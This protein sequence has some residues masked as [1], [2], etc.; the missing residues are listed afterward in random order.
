MGRRSGALILIAALCLLAWIWQQAGGPSWYGL[1]ALSLFAV[2]I[3][4]SWRPHPAT[5]Q[6]RN[7]THND[8]ELSDAG[9]D[10]DLTG[11]RIG[12]VVPVYN[13]DPAMLMACLESLLAQTRPVTSVVVIDDCSTD[14]GAYREAQTLHYRFQ[15]AG[16]ALIT[17]RFDHNQGKRHAL[18]RALELQP[19]IDVLVGV[20]SDTI[21][22]PEAIGRLTQAYNRPGVTVVTGLVLA[23][24]WDRNLLTRLIDL[25]YAQAF[26]V[27]R[28][29]QSRFGSM[30]CACGSLAMYSARVLRK[31]KPDFLNQRFLGQPAIF[32]D[33]RRLTNY[34]L[35]EGKAILEETAIA[36]TAVPEHLPHFLRQQIRWNKSFFR[37][38]LW[39]LRAMPIGKPAFWFTLAEL[40][41]WIIFTTTL[42][43]ALIVA[44]LITTQFLIGPYL[45][46]LTL[47]AYARAFRYPDLTGVRPSTK[48]RWL[49]FAIA[50]LYGLL[51]FTILIW[52]RLW[53]LATLRH[54][55][56]GTRQHIEV[57]LNQP[58]QVEPAHT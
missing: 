13:E 4:M 40:G 55:T 57:T 48:D 31:Y 8:A 54:G 15:Q 56:W 10:S 32:G 14:V 3:I 39:V 35:L 25:R 33:D 6:H 45:G 49:G 30:L 38:S 1:A 52:L 24:N 42:V 46:Y 18:M 22:D 50:P 5:K 27:D 16:I 7:K 29:A 43:Y 37:E 44:P 26:L 51:H 53:S 20:D 23:L 41:T 58:N 11:L 21:T 47:L 19:G 9:P 28:G 12:V 17:E 34:C 2:K 36:Y